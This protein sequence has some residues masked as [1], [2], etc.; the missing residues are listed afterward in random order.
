MEEGIMKSMAS[1]LALLVLIVSCATPA[2][3]ALQYLTT[4]QQLQDAVLEW[5]QNTTINFTFNGWRVTNVSDSTTTL[6]SESTLG[7]SFFF[8]TAIT[9]NV[10][11]VARERYVIVAISATT[12]SGN[13]IY[14]I[15]D[16]LMRFLDGRFTRVRSS[17]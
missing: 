11:A 13:P 6:M 9:L 5:G 17:L 10:S 16:G 8:R 2:R 1:I 15:E 3:P 4:K 7:T 12:S 14:E